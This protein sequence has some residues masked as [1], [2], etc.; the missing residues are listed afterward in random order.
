M[1]PTFDLNFSAKSYP[2]IK[3]YERFGIAIVFSNLRG[4]AAF[5]LNSLRGYQQFF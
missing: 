2:I 4:C 3:K 1:D 5:K